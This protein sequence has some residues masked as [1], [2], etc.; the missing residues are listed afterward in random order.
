MRLAKTDRIAGLDAT[1]VR[2]LMRTMRDPTTLQ[3]VRSRLPAGID[4][5]TVVADLTELGFLR[6]DE[7]TTEAG[8]GWWVTTTT[9]NALAMASFAKPITR[10]TAD[11]LLSGLVDRVRSWNENPDRL[12][13]IDEVVVF[14]SYLD[15]TVDR[16]GDVD[17]AVTLS[18]WP[19]GQSLDTFNKRVKAHCRASGRTFTS[20]V[21]EL[22]WPTKEAIQTLKNRSTAL[23]ITTEDIH[24]LTDNIRVVY[25]R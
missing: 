22:F 10:T 19:E 17:I 3:H 8:D 1:T 9:G 11:K 12:I 24:Q 16:L 15:P 6:P 18:H 21:D 7:R 13:S 20:F 23:N 5:G 14:G 4:A 2:D 25:H